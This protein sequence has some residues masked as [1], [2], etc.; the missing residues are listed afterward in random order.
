MF[1]RCVH[2][3]ALP[4]WYMYAEQASRVY[5]TVYGVSPSVCPSMG[6]Q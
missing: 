3:L 4:A 2:L 5:E 6:P 1:Q